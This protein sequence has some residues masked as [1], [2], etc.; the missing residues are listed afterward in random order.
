MEDTNPELESF[1]EQWRREVTARSSKDRV[2][3]TAEG[4]S[5]SPTPKSSANRALEPPLAPIPGRKDDD[6]VEDIVLKTYHDLEDKDSPFRLGSDGASGSLPIGLHHGNTS[7][8]GI[9]SSALEHYE[10][11]V[12]KE[13]QGSLGESLSLYRK[14]YRMDASV[15]KT[16]KNKHFPSSFHPK[17]SNPQVSNKIPNAAS[18]T[19]QGFQS[20]TAQLIADFANLSINPAPPPTEGSPPLAC[21]IATL[22]S[23]ILV[24][25]LL[26]SAIADVASFMRLAQVCRRFA[27]LVATEERVWKRVCCGA[28]FGFGAMHYDYR[29]SILGEPL[30]DGNGEDGGC[31]LSNLLS[32]EP[33]TIK[34]PRPDI[35]ATMLSLLHTTY[36]SSWRLMFQTRPRIR[37]GGIYISTV[38]YVRSGT[39]SANQVSWN[40][41]VHIVTYYRYLRF[42]RDGTVLSLLTV[43][44]PADV[45]HYLTKDNISLHSTGAASAL[46]SAVVKDTLLG[47]WR[48]SGPASSNSNGDE[49]LEGDV[50]IETE[51][52]GEKGKYFYKLHLSIRSASLASNSKKPKGNKL[53]WKGFWSYNRLT[54]DWAEFG[55]RND[56]AFF[57]SRVRSYGL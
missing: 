55:L 41:P 20:S 56:R 11:A 5:S 12:E 52:V 42:F 17:S 57:W 44:E 38:N 51:G 46:P 49:E 27:Y 25:V 23:E 28:E 10:K 8:G 37:F 34:P 3:L 15:D 21:P 26:Y 30:P 16:Y 19:L 22:P 40:T 4:A 33:S 54:D 50:H 6:E 45:V 35:S 7:I 1:R 18:H 29:C 36:A 53:V 39:S 24:E 31:L 14:A 47:R 9:P 2:S 32:D 13:S 43:A 48:L